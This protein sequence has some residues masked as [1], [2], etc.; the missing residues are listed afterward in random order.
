M[1]GINGLN[2]VLEIFSPEEVMFIFLSILCE[3][4]LIIVSDSLHSLCSAVSFFTSLIKPFRWP[5]PQI[6]S[7]PSKFLEML[8]SVVPFVC[9][10]KISEQ[11]FKTKIMPQLQSSQKNQV[12][13]MYLDSHLVEPYQFDPSELPLPLLGGVWP[14]WLN[15]ASKLHHVKKSRTIDIE[16]YKSPEKKELMRFKLRSK[17]DKKPSISK[18]K[19]KTVPFD[20]EYRN[21]VLTQATTP[22]SAK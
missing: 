3:V 6:Y 12:V 1:E 7:L 16:K 13:F 17:P 5:F 8:E 14:N 18:P 9:G 20:T 2:H 11:D 22:S 4:N 15:D 19:I 21:P 10:V